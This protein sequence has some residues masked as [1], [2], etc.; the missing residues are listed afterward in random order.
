[1]LYGM[2][3]E[4]KSCTNAGITDNLFFEV[5]DDWITKKEGNIRSSE[6]GVWVYNI[7]YWDDKVNNYLPA[8]TFYI[9]FFALKDFIKNQF[10]QG[11]L[12][13]RF[14][15]K[16]GKKQGFVL[17]KFIDII[18][19]LLDPEE[20]SLFCFCKNILNDSIPKRCYIINQQ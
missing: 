12:K 5:W 9:D 17:V 14:K 18:P 10:N 1:M 6:A 4:V 15:W 19:F 11:L 16:N 13:A 8:Y 3:F 2:K 7:L 20:L